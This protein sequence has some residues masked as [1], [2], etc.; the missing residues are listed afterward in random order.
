[1][2]SATDVVTIR[3]DGRRERGDRT[4]ST[5][6]EGAARVASVE[7]LEGLSIG[8]LADHL[9]ISKSGLY[10]HFRSKEELQLATILTA[11]AIYEREVVAPAMEA[12]EGAPRLLAFCD[13][14]FD[15]V[16]EGVFPGGCFF[17]A[18][19]L[20]PAAA[21]R[22]RVKELLAR[23]QRDTLDGLE[24]WVREAQE[25]D[26]VAAGR[27]PR[28]V[29]FEIDSLMTGADRNFVLFTDPSFLEDG[30]RSIRRLLS[31]SA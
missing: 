31:P 5:I 26:K 21:R 24:E 13:K 27:D 9:G 23:I 8:R 14:F 6:L 30:R 22:G 25:R 10:A 20:D 7:G 4:R 28:D 16:R 12:A 3:P 11:E 2:N 29:A 18:N 15:Y 17:V 19:S 1:M